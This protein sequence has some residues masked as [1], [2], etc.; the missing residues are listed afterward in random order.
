MRIGQESQQAMLF[1][2]KPHSGEGWSSSQNRHVS[3]GP[4]LLLNEAVD[5]TIIEAVVSSVLRYRL[6]IP[7][8]ARQRQ[9][10][11]FPEPIAL[12]H[13]HEQVRQE[14]PA[15]SSAVVVAPWSTWSSSNSRMRLLCCQ[16]PARCF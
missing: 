12:D 1:E 9:K 15:V 11:E 14:I 5:L 10:S 4:E 8:H 7:M 2:D 6:H 13:T 16:L 3:Q